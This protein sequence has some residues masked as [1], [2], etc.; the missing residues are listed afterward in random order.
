MENK[1][2]KGLIALAIISPL[3]VVIILA[4][5]LITGNLSK[6]TTPTPTETASASVET[7]STPA[8]TEP[9]SS[10][11]QTTVAVSPDETTTPTTA[12]E[13]TATTEPTT[14]QTE[15]TTAQTEPTAEPTTEPTTEST[16]EPVVQHVWNSGTVIKSPSYKESGIKQ[17]T[18]VDCGA[19]KN[20]EIDRLRVTVVE[21]ESYFK[22]NEIQERRRFCVTLADGTTG[23][24][25][26]IY[27]APLSY[28]LSHGRSSDRNFDC[29]GDINLAY[30]LHAYVKGTDGEWHEAEIKEQSELHNWGFGTYIK[31]DNI[32]SSVGTYEAKIVIDIWYYPQ[33]SMIHPTAYRGYG[34]IDLNEQIVI[35]TTVL[36]KEDIDPSW[37]RWWR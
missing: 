32:I 13:P 36:V 18:C 14:A 21:D 20:E 29:V 33:Y 15:P 12:S 7:V 17:Y 6:K 16:T 11:E 26:F 3:I 27:G 2:R 23:H 5:V 1:G 19:T 28:S 37:A 22:K 4:A 31:A 30:A 25:Q 34:E 9:T 10:T 8:A 35:N 24:L